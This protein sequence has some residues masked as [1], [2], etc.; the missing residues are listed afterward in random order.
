MNQGHLI[1]EIARRTGLNQATVHSVMESFMDTVVEQ[2]S[3]G[4]NV[5]LERF[6]TFRAHYS[7]DRMARNPRTGEP[8]AVP[9]R[10]TMKFRI[11]NKAA[12]AIRS[13]DPSKRKRS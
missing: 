11:S 7:P 6:G 10:N 5:S 1:A 8:I 4:T 13:G 2:V 3:E 12:E 9:A